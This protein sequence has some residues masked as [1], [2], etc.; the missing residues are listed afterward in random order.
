MG[1]SCTSPALAPS[2]IDGSFARARKFSS[3]P[4]LFGEC[5]RLVWDKP[6]AVIASIAG[7]SPRAARDYLNGKVA[8]PSIVLAA[9]NVE[10]TRRD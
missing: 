8:V 7:C 3:K 2:E 1:E 4:C 6:D 10:I 5:A 9:L